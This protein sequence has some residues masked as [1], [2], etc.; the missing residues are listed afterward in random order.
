MAVFLCDVTQ[1]CEENQRQRE[2]V[3]FKTSTWRPGE[4]NVV[5]AGC[6]ELDLS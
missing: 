4:A 5:P 1:C 6:N 3:Q 2:H